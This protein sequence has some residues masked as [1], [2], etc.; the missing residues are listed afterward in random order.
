[1]TLFIE[2]LAVTKY[3]LTVTLLL[4]FNN[5]CADYVKH[6]AINKEEKTVKK[7]QCDLEATKQT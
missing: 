2:L 3:E 6:L 5:S 4:A 7:A 1:L